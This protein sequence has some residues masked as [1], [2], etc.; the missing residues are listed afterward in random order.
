MFGFGGNKKQ[1][2]SVEE[3]TLRLQKAVEE[4]TNSIDNKLVR[5]EQKRSF[6]CCAQ[7]CDTAQD[8]EALMRCVDQCQ[9]RVS[10]QQQVVNQLMQDFQNRLQ[11][12]AM[13]C[14]DM[15]KELLPSNPSSQ[16]IEKAQAKGQECVADC[17]DE[18]VNQIPKLQA[19]LEQA[20][21]RA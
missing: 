17:S 3:R 18:Y 4:M 2:L 6:E 21:R 15:A 16:D 7:C 14:N 11:R 8:Q 9:Q 13:R 10:R 1:T 12:C 20:L 5:P 19:D